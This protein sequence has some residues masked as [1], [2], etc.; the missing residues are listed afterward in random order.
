M[1]EEVRDEI[2]PWFIETR[3][4][5]EQA[6]EKIHKLDYNAKYIN[7]NLKVEFQSSITKY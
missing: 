5:Q 4:V 2:S 1:P 6:V 7:T 3:A